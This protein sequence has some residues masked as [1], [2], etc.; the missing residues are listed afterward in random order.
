MPLGRS[1][2]FLEAMAV[3][4]AEAAARPRRRRRFGESPVTFWEKC[5]A[6]DNFPTWKH[7]RDVLSKLRAN[8]RRE[9]KPKTCVHRLYAESEPEECLSRAVLVCSML[10][11]SFSGSGDPPQLT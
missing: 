7:G 6:C 2:R 1:P 3:A 9:A 8:G 11:S 10:F 4:A 5:D